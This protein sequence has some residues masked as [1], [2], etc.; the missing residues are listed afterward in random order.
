[1][2]I[3]SFKQV[4]KMPKPVKITGRTS[5]ITN[6]FVNGIIPVIEPTEEEIKEALS[7]LGMNESTICCAYCGDSFTEWDH[8]RPLVVNKTATGYVSEIHNLVP[9]CGKCNQ[10]KGNQNW[11]TWMFSNAKLSPATR[12]IPD[13]IKRSERLQKYENWSTPLKVDIESIVGKYQ[14]QQHWDNCEKIKNLMY[15][16]QV[17]SD[18]I[19][20]TLQNALNSHNQELAK[21]FYNTQA[22]PDVFS[23]T[24]TATIKN[25]STITNVIS[26]TDTN[27]TKPVGKIVQF[28]LIPLLLSGRIDNT[29]LS[30][31][32]KPDYSKQMFDVNFPVLLH[33][34]SIS[35]LKKGVDHT[36]INRYYAKP[37]TINGELFLITSQWYDRNKLKL[38]QWMKTFQ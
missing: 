26:S 11:H 23:S 36:G 34:D 1:M 21:C 9:S 33:I 30:F 4:F 6:S 10:S 24:N 15:E 5:S 19:K 25:F 2:K 8:L 22:S 16:S 13:I 3:M 17:L 38:L 18:E 27:E 31:L 29:I 28:E 14:W 20:E 12:N 32:Q 7:I 37:I 35:D